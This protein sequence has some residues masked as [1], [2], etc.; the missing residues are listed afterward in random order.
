MWYSSMDVGIEGGYCDCC[1]IWSDFCQQLLSSEQLLVFVSC[2]YGSAL[3]C[4]VVHFCFTASDFCSGGAWFESRL[5][6]QC[7]V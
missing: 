1:L 2:A 6:H 3:M 7:P 4:S 5:K